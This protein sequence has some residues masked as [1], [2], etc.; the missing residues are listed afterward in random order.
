MERDTRVET[1]RTVVTDVE[2]ELSFFVG[3][4]RLRLRLRDFDFREA[5]LLRCLDLARAGDFVF[6]GK[7]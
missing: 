4:L 2:F 7:P 5:D 6:K 3:V 1:W